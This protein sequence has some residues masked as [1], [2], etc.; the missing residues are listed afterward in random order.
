MSEEKITYW[1]CPSCRRTKSTDL[2]VKAVI[3][4]CDAG[5]MMEKLGEHTEWTY[6]QQPVEI[7]KQKPVVPGKWEEWK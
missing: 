1:V 6:K 7:I 5:A 2:R 3:C 4:P